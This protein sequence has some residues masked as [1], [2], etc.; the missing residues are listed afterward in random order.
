MRFQIRQA[1]P[2]DTETISD[3]NFRMALET[4]ERELDR[5]V[6][7]NGVR[8]VL[9]D[10]SKGV[11]YV[12]ENGSEVV[13]QLMLTYEWSDWRNGNFWWI[14]SVY[15]KPEYRRQGIFKSLYNHV[16]QLARGS[17]QVC[18]LRLYVERH[19]ARA[20]ETYQQLG[21]RRTVYEMFEIDF[22]LGGTGR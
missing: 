6:L 16:E 19:N 9:K 10:A 1:T 12:A 13:G 3:F 14:Q 4:E 17:M 8:S 22:V 21:M 2:A 20:Q 7:T 11:Y 18:G 5:A 15:V